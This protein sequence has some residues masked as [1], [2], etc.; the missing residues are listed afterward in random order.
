MHDFEMESGTSSHFQ[1]NFSVMHFL[2]ICPVPRMETDMLCGAQFN[3]LPTD[4]TLPPLKLSLT[5]YI[6]L[7]YYL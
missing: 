4:P 2:S 5:V 6:A 3:G 1:G 7:A